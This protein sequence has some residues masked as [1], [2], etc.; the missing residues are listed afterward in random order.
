VSRWEQ[1]PLETTVTFPGL[2]AIVPSARRFVRGILAE[3]PR[4]GDME[5]IT[6]EL[7][8]NAILH[9]PSGGSGGEF[10]LTVRTAP[11]WARV[12]VADTGT[13]RWSAPRDGPDDEEYGRGLAI[14]AALADKLGHDIRAGGQT[15][16]AE[17]TW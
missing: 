3:S 12:E 9:S 5:L 13:G 8:S 15:V 10:T 1:G 17:V 16:W 6:A 14:V 11:G 7:A 2:P 4:A